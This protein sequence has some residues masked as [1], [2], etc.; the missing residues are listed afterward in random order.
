MNWKDI[1]ARLRGLGY[2][3]GK[4]DGIPGSGTI[5]GTMAALD[6]LADLLP[7]EDVGADRPVAA[8][9][10]PPPS[11][12]I[13]DAKS[14]ARLDSAHPKLQRLVEAAL[15]RGQVLTVLDSQRGEAEQELAFRRGNS[16]AHFGQS[17]HNW[18][19]SVAVD[20]VPF[21][22]GKVDWDNIA[23][24][25]RMGRL[26]GCYNPNTGQGY[27]LAKEMGIPIRWL[28]DPNFDGRLVDG[29]DFPHFELHPWRAY[30]S[31]PYTG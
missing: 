20:L 4:I 5:S 21:A 26:I 12:A 1:Q 23:A 17:A 22:A 13:L 18:S 14:R 15:G 19:P 29:W 8:V 27:G 9:P 11:P 28:G 6:K 16:K 3:S 10:P 25:H 24:F 7:R 30:A 31:K 2:Y